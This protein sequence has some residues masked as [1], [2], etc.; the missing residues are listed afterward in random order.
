MNRTLEQYILW[1]S[2]FL[3]AA[4]LFSLKGRPII[5]Q[6]IPVVISLII[7]AIIVFELPKII[8]L[9]LTSKSE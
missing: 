3:G 1:E 6:L 2:G 8:K 4:F 7:Y 9:V 5:I